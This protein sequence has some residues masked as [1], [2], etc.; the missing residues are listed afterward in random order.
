MASDCTLTR[1]IDM[2][3]IKE[4]KNIVI[5]KFKIRFIDKWTDGNVLDVLVD[6]KLTRS[7]KSF[8]SSNNLGHKCGDSKIKDGIQEVSINLNL[9]SPVWNLKIKEIQPGPVWGIL[10]FEVW[11]SACPEN[12]NAISKENSLQEGCVC[13]IG[14][15]QIILSNVFSCV[16]CSYGC[17][18]CTGPDSCSACT[19]GYTIINQKCLMTG[20]KKYI[21]IY[22]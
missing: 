8:T 12:S 9:D 22:L 10:D 6:D 3:Y 11:T 14:F 2:S 15:Y 13:N 1:K 19:A 4:L 16:R 18:Q 20:K 17:T 5:L 21:Y 7:I